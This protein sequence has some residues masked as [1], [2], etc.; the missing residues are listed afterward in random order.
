MSNELEEAL[1]VIKNFLR[2]STN[3]Q[4][5]EI[6]STEIL[7]I[8]LSAKGYNN[9]QNFIVSGEQYFFNNILSKVNPKLCLD[10][11]ASVGGYTRRLLENSNSTVI[12]FE[13][14]FEQFKSLQSIK[15]EFPERVII[16]NLGVGSVHNEVRS[17]YFNKD[18][19]SHASFSKEVLEIP[20]LNNEESNFINLVSLD[21]YFSDKDALVDFIKIDVEGFEAEVLVGAQNL[22]NTHKPKMIQIEFN[23]HQLFRAQSLFSISQLLKNYSPFQMLSDS[24]IQRD[25]KDPYSNI[26]HFSNFLF[27]RD[28]FDFS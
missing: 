27:I 13:P 26:Y 4:E 18:A 11:G 7:N 3:T 1:S 28:D 16:E 2:E 24:L 12:A 8:A 14:I 20:Y 10:V 9:Y 25:P 23:W 22:I 21:G 6:F 15:K 5:R 17:I 19:M